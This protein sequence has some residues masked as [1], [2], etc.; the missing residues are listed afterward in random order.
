MQPQDE[1]LDRCHRSIQREFAKLKAAAEARAA[2]R[3]GAPRSVVTADLWDWVEE[4]A[5]ATLDAD[6][7][8]AV[9]ERSDGAADDED[10][11]V[12]QFTHV[13]VRMFE[14]F[15]RVLDK[16]GCGYLTQ[17]RCV[18][19]L[20]G[21]LPCLERLGFGLSTSTGASHPVH[22]PSISARGIFRQGRWYPALSAAVVPV[23]NKV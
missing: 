22:G 20:C 3:P 4:Q 6:D 19:C 23:H 16:Q 14:Q 7:V 18:V 21:P 15:F 1:V 13:V 12:E 2:D 9:L 17:V 5:G 8:N 11:S 10:V